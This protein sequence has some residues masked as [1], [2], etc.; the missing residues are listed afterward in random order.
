MKQPHTHV[1]LANRLTSRT[2]PL[3]QIEVSLGPAVSGWVLRTAAVLTT[4]GFALACVQRA[5]LIEWLAWVI[6]LLA[7]VVMAIWTASVVAHSTVVI[8]GVLLTLSHGPFDPIVFWLIPLAYLAGRC[9]WWA[10]RVA[11]SGRVELAALA[12]G[13]PRDLA[14]VVGTLALGAV[15]L[16]VPGQSAVLMIVGGVAAVL[17]AWLVFA[18]PGQSRSA[19]NTEGE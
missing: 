1:S 12:V 8:A 7:S 16:L 15:V 5:G 4:G 19:R 11:L 10:E 2:R 17:L 9:A 3:P 18:V 6:V 14:V 13:L